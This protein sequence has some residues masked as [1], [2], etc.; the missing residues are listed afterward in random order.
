LHE[1]DR[2]IAQQMH[3]FLVADFPHA[4]RLDLDHL[5]RGSRWLRQ[6]EDSRD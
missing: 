4:G 3:E 6:Y 5:W 1:G 2:L